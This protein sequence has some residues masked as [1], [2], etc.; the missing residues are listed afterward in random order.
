MLA[1][2]LGNIKDDDIFRDIIFYSVQWLHYLLCFYLAPYLP[3]TPENY[4][5]SSYA[6]DLIDC[7]CCW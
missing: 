2:W 4:W 5:I 6:E 1:Y 7:I 3:K